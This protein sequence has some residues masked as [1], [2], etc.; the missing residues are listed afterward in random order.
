MKNRNKVGRT[1]RNKKT[2]GGI[3]GSGRN[4]VLFRT[5]RLNG[6]FVLLLCPAVSLS[7]PVQRKSFFHNTIQTTEVPTFSAQENCLCLISFRPA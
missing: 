7:C 5:A 3:S 1:D 4:E 6:P 2:R